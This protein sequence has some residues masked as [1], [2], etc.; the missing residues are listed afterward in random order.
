[1]NRVALKPCPFCGSKNVTLEDA[2]RCVKMWFI[3]CDYCDATFP[4]FES[5][6]TAIRYWN[7]RANEK[8]D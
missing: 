8:A 5:K 4:H 2:K 3:Q 1:M 7:R 6:Y